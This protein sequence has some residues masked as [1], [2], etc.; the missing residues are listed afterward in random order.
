MP[1]LYA[2]IQNND[3]TKCWQGCETMQL[4]FTAGGNTK[5][6]QLLLRQFGSFL[7]NETFLSHDTAIV[8]PGIY[9]KEFKTCLHTKTSTQMFVATLFIAAKT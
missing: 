5:M 1:S 2:Q 6:L 9:P 4:L 7:Q 8:L 3:N